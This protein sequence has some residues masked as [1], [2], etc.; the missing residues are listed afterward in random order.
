MDQTGELAGQRSRR[1]PVP[2]DQLVEIIH[3][4]PGV[5]AELEKIHGQQQGMEK[6][7]EVPHRTARPF[8][9]FRVALPEHQPALSL[10]SPRDIPHR[11]DPVRAVRDGGS[12]YS[13]LECGV[14]AVG[15]VE[16]EGHS[17]P[18]ISLVQG[19]R[20]GLRDHGC[21]GG[22]FKAG[23][24]AVEH[25]GQAGIGLADHVPGIPDQQ[26]DGRSLELGLGEPGGILNPSLETEEAE[27]RQD[28][29]EGQQQGGEREG[30]HFPA[31]TFHAVD[32]VFQ[33]PLV[34]VLKV[35]EGGVRILEPVGE[36][37]QLQG[38]T[39]L[40]LPA[41]ERTPFLQVDPRGR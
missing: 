22:I 12:R 17:V 1:L 15:T 28:E 7:F 26:P 29:G 41:P 35:P 32:R 11:C 3:L 18:W 30:R 25:V 8:P 21:Q 5:S 31:V 39:R 6:T 24:G 9:E 13:G 27:A 38:Q 10:D 14:G 36:V 37:S 2:L 20:H 33:K 34:E 23:L 4:L 16:V 19:G 40:R